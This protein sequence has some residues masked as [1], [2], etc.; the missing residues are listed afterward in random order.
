MH[1]KSIWFI[2]GLALFVGIFVFLG[3]GTSS[4]IPDAVPTAVVHLKNGEVYELRAGYV[5][6]SLAGRKMKMLAYNGMIPGPDIHVAEGDIA[7][8]HFVNDLDIPT[9][10]H[11]HGVRMDNPYD[12][13][14]LVQADILP[15]GSFDYMLKFPDP[16]MYWY[17]PH[18]RE[19]KQQN[20]GLFGS[21]IVEPK[22]PS[23]W[24]TA[25]H[26]ET[27]FLSDVYVEEGEIAPYSDKYITHALMGRFGNTQ[28]ING[29]AAFVGHGE[30]GEVHRLYV[31]NAATV[32]PFN[33]A[34]T[35]AK[36]K[37]IGSDVGR[38]QKE[39]FVESV[40]LGPAER[41][42]I[43]VYF[44]AAGTYAIENKTPGKTY[45]LG[46]FEIAG[47]P[48]DGARKTYEALR[49]NQRETELFSG[50]RH[51]LN[52]PVDKTVTLTVDVDMAKIMNYMG[53][54][55]SHMSPMSMGTDTA[56]GGAMAGHVAA[57]IEWDDTMGDMNTFSTS[58][59]VRWII[60]DEETGLTNMDVMWQFPQGKFVKI[61]IV[62]DAKSAHPMQH[63]F[64]T[65]GNRFVVLAT[66]G[67]LN[68][69][70]AWKD[71]TLIKAGD[72][73]D[74]ILDPSNLGKWMAHCHIAEH[75][76]SGMMIGFEVVEA[77]KPEVKSGE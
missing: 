42:I 18:I 28:L 14:Q 24:P 53:G 16:G 72:T 36:M 50:L 41:A 46:K 19:D 51:Y 11:S 59:T 6:K 21:F 77:A 43:D 73:V 68:D 8:I 75:L 58:E 62:N 38:Y 65:H 9:L 49:V 12:G 10:L 34:I 45:A 7:T 5:M 15:G 30:P 64:H 56:M 47:T 4:A 54:G 74:I 13:S 40:I 2:F 23:F 69:N 37:L 22:D 70:M 48:V 66:N 32:R 44:P 29:D 20:M 31:A 17:H 63:P 25:D 76:H 39:A 33:F 27:L 1:K 71:T 55:M 35:G 60:R 57:P 3:G 61:R 26:Q 52:M 67:I